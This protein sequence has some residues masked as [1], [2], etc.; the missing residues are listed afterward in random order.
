MSMPS[1]D[2]QGSQYAQPKKPRYPWSNAYQRD[3]GTH[4]EYVTQ[5]ADEITASETVDHKSSFHGGWTMENSKKAL[6]E[7]TQKMKL[8]QVVYTTKIK[9]A[10]TVRLVFPRKK[11]SNE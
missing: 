8:P 10:N 3:E 11:A 4:E 7:Y 9:E 2:T 6:N 1:N 5:K